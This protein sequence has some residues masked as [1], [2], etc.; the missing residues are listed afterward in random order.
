MIIRMIDDVLTTEVFEL[1]KNRASSDWGSLKEAHM[2]HV[3][4]FES[5]L[6]TFQLLLPVGYR[7]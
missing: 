7:T 1:D 6:S 2:A 5:L 3:P 4:H